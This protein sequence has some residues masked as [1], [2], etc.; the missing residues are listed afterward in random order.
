MWVA[1]AERRELGLK[2]LVANRGLRLAAAGRFIGIGT[3]SARLLA[4]AASQSC[5]NPSLRAVFLRAVLRG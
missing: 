5:S 1:F 3:T 2:R 4:S